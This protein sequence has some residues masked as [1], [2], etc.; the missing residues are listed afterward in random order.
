MAK[1]ILE[2][3]MPEDCMTC[4]LSTFKEYPEESGFYCAAFDCRV[5]VAMD[6]DV[7]LLNCPLKEIKE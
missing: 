2:L 5:R 4:T 3:E 6:S 1:A 7:R